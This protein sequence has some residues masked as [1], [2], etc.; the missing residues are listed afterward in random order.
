MILIIEGPDGAGK[1]TFAKG[2]GGKY[3][4]EGPPPTDMGPG[5]LLDYYLGKV[6]RAT[7]ETTVF[8]RLALGEVIYGPHLRGTSRLSLDDYAK[9]VHETRRLGARH[10]LCLPPF[11]TCLRNWASRAYVG[12]ELIAS[13]Y[14]FSRTYEAFERYHAATWTDL[15]FD[16]T[17]GEAR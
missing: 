12:R 7:H 6:R 1:T 2:F 14:V 4:H 15:I 13:E 5:N 9:F 17:K 11:E 3:Y 10:V 16:Y 8:D